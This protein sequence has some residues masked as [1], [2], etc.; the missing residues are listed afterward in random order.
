MHGASFE[1]LSGVDDVTV[2]RAYSFVG[3][4]HL[5]AAASGATAG[6]S[7][8][9]VLHNGSH[10]TG[11]RN[12]LSVWRGTDISLG[13]DGLESVTASSDLHVGSRI[14]ARAFADNWEA[15]GRWFWAWELLAS[16]L[17]AALHDPLSGEPVVAK[18]G[19]SWAV[20]DNDTLE[21]WALDVSAE[22]ASPNTAE[23]VS[24][25]LA[26]VTLIGTSIVD[27]Y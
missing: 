1:L 25:S 27:R 4:D 11:A 16:D 26:E 5:T 3:A 13:G 2:I 22:L 24:V 9:G 15:D 17:F 12:L 20:I 7:T 10:R 14:H 19:S 6:P 8:R 21:R 23:T 18:S